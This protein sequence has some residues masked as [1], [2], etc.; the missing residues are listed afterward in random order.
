M[1]ISKKTVVE[2]S[3]F[4][5]ALIWALNFSVVKYS[6][7]EIDPLSFNGLRF[8]F[9]AAIIWAVLFYRRQLFTIPKKDWLPLL[10]MGLLGNIIYQGLFIIGID[11]TYAANAAVMLGTIPIWV[12][13]IS[14][15]FKLEQMNI[16]KTL[17]V[18]AAFGGIIFIV[19]GGQDPFSLSSDTF[20]GDL[21]IIAAAVVWG[22]YTILSKSFLTR[23]TPIQFSAIMATIG[24]IVLFLIGLPNIIHLQWTQ[25][26]AA[27][28]GG[29][30]YSGLLSIGVAYLI[31]N[32]GLQTVGAVHTATYQNLVPVMGLFFGI[33]LLN[34]QLTFLQYIGSALVIAGIVLARWRTSSPEKVPP[35]E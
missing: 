15:F 34:E 8:I 3:L 9:A 21:I 7:V 31:W 26:S 11:Y 4:L 17:G 2:A 30:V 32:Y 5:V 19:S 29:V 14:H 23:Y 28:Y 25:I 22:G 10:G 24:A 20:F 13:L 12:A 33:V 27:A 35:M 18:I 6:L 16:F 1:N